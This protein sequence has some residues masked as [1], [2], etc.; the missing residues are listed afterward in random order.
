[1]FWVRISTNPCGLHNYG[2][3]LAAL[4][5]IFDRNT[6]LWKSFELYLSL[7]LATIERLGEPFLAQVF[8]ILSTPAVKEC[9]VYVN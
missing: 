7:M 8:Q 1:M 5:F 3:D 9:G 4:L 6:F 2:A